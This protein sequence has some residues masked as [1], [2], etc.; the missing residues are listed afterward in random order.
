MKYFEVIAKCGHVG[1]N[2]CIFITFACAA[3]DGKEAA[4]K[5]RLYKRV[6]HNHKDAI[7]DVQEI[8]FEEYMKL[9]S[10]NDADPY[11]HCKNPQEQRKIP[12]FDSRV[13]P[14]VREIQMKKKASPLRRQRVLCREAEIRAELHDYYRGEYVA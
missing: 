10:E 14:D 13:V 6:K 12:D 8:T 3:E 11:L 5:V 7:R 9:R 4:A 1:K 2:K